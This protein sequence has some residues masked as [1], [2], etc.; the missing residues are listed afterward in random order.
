MEVAP[1]THK[2]RDHTRTTTEMSDTSIASNI[3]IMRYLGNSK[4]Q[5]PWKNRVRV[6]DVAKTALQLATYSRKK[7]KIDP[8]M[9]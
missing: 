9:T 8:P 2:H 4:L 5:F 3:C 6:L 7:K 1:N